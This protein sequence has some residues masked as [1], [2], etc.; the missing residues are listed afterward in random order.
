MD[1]VRTRRIVHRSSLSIERIAVPLFMFLYYVATAKDGWMAV[2]VL[3][4]T[5]TIGFFA[6]R[7][8]ERYMTAND[9]IAFLCFLFFVISPVQAISNGHF[10]SDRYVASLPIGYRHIIVAQAI[11]CIFYAGFTLTTSALKRFSTEYEYRLDK[12]SAIMLFG[13]MCFA[14]IAHVLSYG[15]FGNLLAARYERDTEE[16]STGIVIWKGLLVSSNLLLFCAAFGSKKSSYLHKA[17]AILSAVLMLISINP[18]NIARNMLFNAW[19]PLLIVALHGRIRPIHLHVLFIFAIL[20]VMPIFNYTGREGLTL[21][22]SV[23]ILGDNISQSLSGPFSDVFDMLCAATL[24]FDTHAF[25]YGQKT[26]GLLFFF[27][28]RAIWSG[29]ATLTGLDVGGY[30]Y[31]LGFLG[32]PNLSF[33][34]G[35]DFYADFGLLGPLIGAPLAALIVYLAIYQRG[36][37]VN[38][39]KV[40]LLLYISTLPILIRGPV[41]ANVG[42]LFFELIFIALLLRM[43]RPIG[44]RKRAR[45]HQRQEH[46][47]PNVPVRVA[48]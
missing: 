23:A 12:L 25:H 21:G 11:F 1:Y 13:I 9:V 19:F 7:E 33:F 42:L 4:A 14:F 3:P 5:L 16:L 38:G 10:T 35:G 28:P 18:F 47:L 6:L 20:I 22:D 46:R 24:W 39:Y 29:K 41:G 34:I 2:I 32:T 43:L 37:S 15:S 17:L 48:T 8:K 40:K 36:S 31:D 30:L 45:A 27:I 26:V 44:I